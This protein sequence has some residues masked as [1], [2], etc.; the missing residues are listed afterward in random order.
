MEWVG[1]MRD[2]YLASADLGKASSRSSTISTPC[3]CLAT[4]N[5]ILDAAS[6]DERVVYSSI[7]RR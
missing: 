4:D 1:G 3:L 2:V 5:A 6:Y 7:T